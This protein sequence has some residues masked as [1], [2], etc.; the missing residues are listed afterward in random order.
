MLFGLAGASWIVALAPRLG[1]GLALAGAVIGG[2]TFVLF[3]L[4]VTR[5]TPLPLYGTVIVAL[6]LLGFGGAGKILLG[7]VTLHGRQLA[8]A[9][10]SSVGALVWAVTMLIAALVAQGHRDCR[11]S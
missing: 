8:I 11:G 9:A 6:A 3:I 5:F 1:G 2:F 4:V 7:H 10:A